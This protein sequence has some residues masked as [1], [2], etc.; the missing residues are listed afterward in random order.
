VAVENKL[1]PT[2][3]AIGGVSSS[4][5][6]NNNT[7][8]KSKC[9]QRANDRTGQTSVVSVLVSGTKSARLLMMDHNEIECDNGLWIQPSFEEK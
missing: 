2:G 6:N 8:G 5:G 4:S 7:M 3:L 1:E 9:R